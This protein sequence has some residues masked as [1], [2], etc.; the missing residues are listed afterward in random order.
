MNSRDVICLSCGRRFRQRE[1]RTGR[2]SNRCCTGCGSGY[3]V[4][5]FRTDDGELRAGAPAGDGELCEDKLEYANQLRRY[6]ESVESRSD[7][8]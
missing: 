2:W 8:S 3:L 5:V 4:E 1:Y 7:L 6:P